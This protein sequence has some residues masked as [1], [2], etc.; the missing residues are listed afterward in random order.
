MLE[1]STHLQF[2]CLCPYYATGKY[3]EFKL[4]N[5]THQLFNNGTNQTT[6]RTPTTANFTQ[7][8]VNRT[9]KIGAQYNMTERLKSFVS[10]ITSHLS[11]NRSANGRYKNHRRPMM[12]AMRQIVSSVTTKSSTF[13]PR[14]NNSLCNFQ[15]CQLGKCLSN[16]T[17][18]CVRPA[19]G[20]YCD[21]I[22]EC[23]ILKCIHV[24]YLINCWHQSQLIDKYWF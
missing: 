10:N 23:L 4:A 7:T 15:T 3:C 19:F 9:A 21:Q 11:S 24:N 13:I 18:Q 12:S 20:K 2:K 6:L 5:M 22:D 1:D 16:G 17:C 14:Q 8:L